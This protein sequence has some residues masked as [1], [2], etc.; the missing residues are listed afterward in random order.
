MQGHLF[1]LWDK[2]FLLLVDEH[3]RYKIAGIME[4]K[5]ATDYLKCLCSSWVRFLGPMETFV[6][7]Q[8]GALTLVGA[9]S[10]LKKAGVLKNTGIQQKQGSPKRGPKKNTG[11]KQKHVY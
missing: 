8:E 10:V 6:A 5:T 9:G 1:F 7:D 3:T 2:I 4:R 11:T